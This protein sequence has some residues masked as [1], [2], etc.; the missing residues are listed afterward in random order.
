ME[1]ELGVNLSFR[2]VLLIRGDSTA[3]ACSL[4]LDFPN[5]DTFPQDIAQRLPHLRC[6]APFD[7]GINRPQ[8][9]AVISVP[10][11]AWCARA[12]S[13]MKPAPAFLHRRLPTYRAAPRLCPTSRRL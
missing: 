13:A 10:F 3:R 7:D 11:T 9:V 5:D 4:A 1:K 8:A 6:L 2:S 12:L